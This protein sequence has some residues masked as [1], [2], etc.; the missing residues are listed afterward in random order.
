MK[1]L[2]IAALILGVFALIY[3][4]V[5]YSRQRTILDLGGIHASVTEHHN[6]PLAPIVGG[7]AIVGGLLLIL[8]PKRWD[9]S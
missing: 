6:L 3:G 1:R 2:G 9:P 8:V 7:I 5:T 4:G